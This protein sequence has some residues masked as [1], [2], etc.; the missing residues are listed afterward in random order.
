MKI[1][2]PRIHGYLDYVAVALLALAPSLFGFAGVAATISYVLAVVQLGMSLVTAYPASVAK[3]IPFT[4]HGAV[5][6][7]TAIFLIVAPWLFRFGE[8]DAARN[9]FVASG[10]GLLLVYIATDYKAAEHQAL[11]PPSATARHVTSKT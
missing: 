4:I 9:F 3:L 2:N 6:L 11:T 10:I 5:E 7:V 1:L 8:A